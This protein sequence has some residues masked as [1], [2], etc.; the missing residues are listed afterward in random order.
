MRR[1]LR[2]EWEGNEEEMEGGAK[3]FK[4]LSKKRINNHIFRYFE[5]ALRRGWGGYEE[6][7]RVEG[8]SGNNH[9]NL[10]YYF[11]IDITHI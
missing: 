6:G 11:R 10:T 8:V 4:F 9:N 7:M 1:A 5:G 3:L 2:R